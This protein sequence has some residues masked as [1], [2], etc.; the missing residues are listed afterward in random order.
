MKKITLNLFTL[1]VATTIFGQNY[2]TGTI[3]LFSD[4]S[5]SIDVNQDDVTLTLVGP[6][7]AWLGMSFGSVGMD[8]IGKDVVLFDGTNMTDRT[9]DGIGVVPPLDVV[10]NWT[11]QS[12]TIISGIRTVI[13][14]RARDTGD[15]NDYVFSA[16]PGTLNLSFARRTGSLTVGYHGGG[17]CGS[18][19]ANLTLGNAS[20]ETSSFK[21]Y[22][23][24]A[25]GFT[26]I[27]LPEYVRFGEV[28]VYDNLG[29]VVKKQTVSSETKTIN[30]S[31]LSRGSY[32][33]VVRTEFGTATKSLLVE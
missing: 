28:K 17:N 18:T 29:K 4:Y 11:V 21:M 12:N 20:F 30:T 15:S 3:N 31:D 5:G 32:L 1:L 19:V 9:Y 24:P 8:D 27:E 23:N 7:T 2:S 6:S 16:T 10:Q 14:S 13:A 22:P 33:V 26:T 25:Q